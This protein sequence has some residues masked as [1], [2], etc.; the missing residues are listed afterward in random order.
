MGSCGKKAVNGI[1][2]SHCQQTASQD[3]FR[4]SDKAIRVCR[5][6]YLADEIAVSA[7]VF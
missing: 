2:F 4:D 5:Q 1:I 7:A 3:I 6:P